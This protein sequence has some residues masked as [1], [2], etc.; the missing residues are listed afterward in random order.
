MIARDYQHVKECVLISFY[1]K[2]PFFFLVDVLFDF[3]LI[4]HHHVSKSDY[5]VCGVSLEL[6]KQTTLV[7]HLRASF[8]GDAATRSLRTDFHGLAVPDIGLI[9]LLPNPLTNNIPAFQ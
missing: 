2:L 6:T 1:F 5:T 4:N 7:Y 8:H 9:L 3:C